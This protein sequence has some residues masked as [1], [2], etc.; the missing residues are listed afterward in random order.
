MTS[1]EK[2]NK[3]LSD[4]KVLKLY[5]QGKLTMDKK[6]YTSKTLWV[7]LVQVITGISVAV[8]ASLLAGGTITFFGLWMMALRAI[9]NSKLIK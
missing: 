9:T 1:P 3:I 7:G 6:W 4:K 8:E 2:I 5:K